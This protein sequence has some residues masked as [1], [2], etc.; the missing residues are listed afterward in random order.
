MWT[1]ALNV[2]LALES[3]VLIA[4]TATSLLPCSQLQKKDLVAAWR[5]SVE[6]WLDFVSLEEPSCPAKLQNSESLSSGLPTMMTID[7]S[8]AAP[9][10]VKDA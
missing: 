5:P 9:M 2:L 7:S 6:F 1:I 10:T 4:V 8:T 3:K